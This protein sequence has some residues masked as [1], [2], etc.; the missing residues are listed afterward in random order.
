AAD[1]N[2][3]LYGKERLRKFLNDHAEQPLNTMLPSLRSDIEAFTGEA[4]QSD[5]ITILAIRICGTE[6][7]ER[8]VTMTAD[9]ANLDELIAFIDKELDACN[10]PG[11]IRGQVE[12]AA[13]EVFV[14]I[15]D[16]AYS[17][18]NREVTVSCSHVTEQDQITMTLV[19]IDHGR[20][21]NPLERNDPDINLSLDEREPGGM[22]ILIVKK[23]MDTIQYSR[24][25][26][27]NRLELC[28]SWQKELK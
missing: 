4:E 6:P 23:T 7:A 8:S 21:F 18:G 19:F 11:N 20:A 9:I 24:E 2:G 26:G 14:N 16:Y 22:G 3:E 10:C 13:E 27:M 28:K 5:D 12:L 17:E 15:A 25:N 1:V